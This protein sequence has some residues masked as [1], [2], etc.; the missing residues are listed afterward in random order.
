[1]NEFEKN[2]PLIGELVTVCEGLAVAGR[3]STTLAEL[4]ERLHR[5]FEEIVRVFGVMGVDIADF[6]DPTLY[7][8]DHI[9]ESGTR[10][11]VAQRM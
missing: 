10:H 4:S 7:R 6:S 3:V 11:E 5:P 9:I 1:M 8:L 2:L